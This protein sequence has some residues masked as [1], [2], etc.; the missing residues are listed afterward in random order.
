CLATPPGP[1]DSRAVPPRTNA[2]TP[3]RALAFPPP[4]RRSARRLFAEEGNLPHP[5]VPPR[6]AHSQHQPRA[7]GGHQRPGL[8]LAPQ[9]VTLALQ[10]LEMVVHPVGGADVHLLPDLADG[11]RETPLLGLPDDEVEALAL[12]A[13]QLLH[14][15]L[16]C[17]LS[18]RVPP[19]LN[20][21]AESTLSPP[22]PKECNCPRRLWEGPDEPVRT[23]LVAALLLGA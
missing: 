4:H 1:G 15:A 16:P 18:K 6:S 22:D 10:R 20:G 19:C 8:L 7:L 9:Q 13:R 17:T 23:R 5:R 14:R 2:S 11:G 21:P 12:S 3:P